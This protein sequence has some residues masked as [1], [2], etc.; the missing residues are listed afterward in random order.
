MTKF[1]YDLSNKKVRFATPVKPRA[2]LEAKRRPMVRAF[3]WNK[4]HSADY[5][6]TCSPRK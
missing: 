5:T 2:D 1:V 3:N 4:S 6:A